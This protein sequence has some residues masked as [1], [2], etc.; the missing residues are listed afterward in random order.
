LYSQGSKYASSW[1]FGPREEGNRSVKEVVE[2]LIQHWGGSARWEKDGA[3]QPHEASLLKL[4]CSKAHQL[5]GWAPRWSL[6]TS[7]EKIVEWQKSF[8]NKADMRSL[9]IAQ[10]EEYTKS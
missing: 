5:L 10:I 1:N 4:D 3:E 6:E 2:I 8:L 9:S 7:I